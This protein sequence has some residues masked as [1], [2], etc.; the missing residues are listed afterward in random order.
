MS[1]IDRSIRF[2]W[3]PQLARRIR[4]YY[5][6]GR[7]R[8][9]ATL[10]LT[11]GLLLLVFFYLELAL[12]SAL[13]S[14]WIGAFTFGAIGGPLLLLSLVLYRTWNRALIALPGLA[15]LGW[16]WTYIAVSL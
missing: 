6:S 5:E 4:L 8:F 12:G 2:H 13:S 1:R 11:V 14:Q 9:F 3:L 10:G 7:R 16:F 15:T